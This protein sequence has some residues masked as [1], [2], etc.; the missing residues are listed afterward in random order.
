VKRLLAVLA[1][2]CVANPAGSAQTKT[3]VVYGDINPTAGMTEG[4]GKRDVDR[5]N[6]MWWSIFEK[7]GVRASWVR[8]NQIKTEWA[9]TGEMV[10]NGGKAAT[11]E[12]GAFTEQF[13]A[14]IHIGPV[15]G[16]IWQ[17]GYART[18]SIL[19]YARGG[20]VVPQLYAFD[21]R[22][23]MV[24]GAHKVNDA[25][26]CSTGI[27][28]TSNPAEGGISF[29]VGSQTRPWITAGGYVEG[30]VVNTTSPAGGFRKHVGIGAGMANH[31]NGALFPIPECNWCDSLLST[32]NSDSVLIWERMYNTLPGAKPIVFAYIDGEGTPGDSASES[33]PLPPGEVDPIVMLAALARLDSLT[34]NT[35][36][37]PNKIPQRRAITIDGLCS[38]NSRLG[39]NPGIFN[40][41]TAVAYGSLDSLTAYG[42]PVTFTVNAD[43]DSM[44]AYKRDLIKA[45]QNPAARFTPMVRTG[46]D[47]LAAMNGGATSLRRPRDVWGRYRKRAAYGDGTCAGVDTSL[48]CHL[49]Q[50][51]ALLDSALT[52]IGATNRLS[53][54]LV[55]PDDDWSPKNILQIGGGPPPDSVLWTIAKTGYTGVRI[56]GQDP[57]ANGELGNGAARTN[58]RGWYSNQKRRTESIGGNQ[59]NLLAHTGFPLTGSLRS[60]VY[61]TDTTGVVPQGALGTWTQE[62]NR[63]W[64]GWTQDQ[65]RNLDTF[66]YDAHGVVVADWYA[67]RDLWYRT[68]DMLNPPIKAYCARLSFNDLS[69]IP[70][71]PPARVGWWIIKSDWNAMRTINEIAGRAIITLGYPEDVSP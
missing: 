66:P 37:D 14:V 26:C 28:A 43:P 61:W 63:H 46:L 24:F 34:G 18:D 40:G 25:T 47:S 2:L 23:N 8:G 20:A 9:R 57:A 54:F 30:Q 15:I 38:R 36:F 45:A 16:T 53:K 49:I 32:T 6:D 65:D 4:H 41:D 19:R 31:Y 58:P 5:I 42:I 3:L 56:D 17:T 67:G 55:A 69:G 50:A 59:L 7:W 71:G 39:I 64:T 11:L 70:N 52:S 48:Y 13:G 22:M 27:S 44:S 60:A 1:L 12:A 35:L 51:R 33:T 62:V 10:W 21:D 29:K 68:V